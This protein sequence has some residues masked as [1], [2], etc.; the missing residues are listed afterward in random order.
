VFTVNGEKKTLCWDCIVN[1][2]LAKEYNRRL[3]G[4][5]SGKLEEVRCGHDQ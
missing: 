3:D 2:G 5:L 1:R 4:L